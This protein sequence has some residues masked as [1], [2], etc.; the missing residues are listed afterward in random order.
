LQASD[1]SIA[2]VLKGLGI[3]VQDVNALVGLN[4]SPITVIGVGSGECSGTSISCD[5]TQFLPAVAIGCVP[6]SA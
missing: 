6:I 4:C 3:S 2:T 5:N 1:P